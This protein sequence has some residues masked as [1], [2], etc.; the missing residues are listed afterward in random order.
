L[1][2]TPDLTGELTVTDACS[3]VTLSQNPLRGT[4]LSLGDHLVTFTATDAASN[5]STCTLTLSVI[6]NSAPVISSGPT[7]KTLSA[8]TNCAAVAPDLTGQIVAADCSP[9]CR[10]SNPLDPVTV[11]HHAVGSRGT[12]SGN[13]IL[14][15]GKGTAIGS[16]NLSGEIRRYCGAVVPALKVLLVGPDEITGALL[17][18]TDRVSVPRAGSWRPHQWL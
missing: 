11:R 7:N 6:D 15:H 9:F 17:S 13:W 16:N 4:A 3:A 14:S 5:S 2:T 1:L 12:G 18:I 8:G 10:D